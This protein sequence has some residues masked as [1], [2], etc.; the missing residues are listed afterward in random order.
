[1]DHEALIDQLIIEL[2]ITRDEA[3]DILSN[4]G[5][6]ISQAK[7]AYM[8]LYGIT[9]T[10]QD[11][12]PPP[13]ET[14]RPTFK[15]KKVVEKE[16]EKEEEFKYVLAETNDKFTERRNLAQTRGRWLVVYVSQTTT[17]DFDPFKPEGYI[18]DYMNTRFVGFVTSLEEPD[19]KWVTNAYQ[20]RDL[21]IYLFIDPVTTEKVDLTKAGNQKDL[22]RFMRSFLIKNSKYGLPIDMIVERMEMEEFEMEEDE[23]EVVKPSA[24]KNLPPPADPGKITT[25]MIQT[26][27]GK[28]CRIEIGENEYINTLYE[29]VS[30]LVSL[31]TDQFRLDLVLPPQQISDKTKT[32]KDYNLRNS[33]IKVVKL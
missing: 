22:S 3:A 1:M 25:Q 15:S 24:P 33:L 30:L 29:K 17:K 27:D 21:P 13:V 5:W 23:E 31:N 4:V 32:I 16:K 26:P 19:G 14:P 10:K 7:D 11:P 20:I 12:P 8:S 2:P 18:R 9:P 6:D 28:K